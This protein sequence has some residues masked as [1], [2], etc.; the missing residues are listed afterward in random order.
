VAVRTLSAGLSVNAGQ[1]VQVVFAWHRLLQ[2][3]PVAVTP[4]SVPAAIK[5]LPVQATQLVPLTT[6][7]A[8]HIICRHPAQSALNIS[9][10]GQVLQNEFAVVHPVT[11]FCVVI[12]VAPVHLHAPLGH[13]VHHDAPFEAN[14]VAAQVVLQLVEVVSLSVPA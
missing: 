12:G 4:L 10:A 6:C 9:P 7:P 2:A 14:A 11:P 3:A 1:A 5:L 8:G 13:V